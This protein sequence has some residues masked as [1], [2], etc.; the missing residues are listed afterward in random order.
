[1]TDIIEAM[2]RA[3]NTEIW[4]APGSN[5]KELKAMRAALTAALERGWKLVPVEPTRDQIIAPMLT[6]GEPY[7]GPSPRMIAEIYRMMIE[8]SPEVK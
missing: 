1:M 2:Q 4:G 5:E 6:G 8:S 3:Y 7:K